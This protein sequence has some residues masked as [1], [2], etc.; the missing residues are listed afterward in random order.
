VLIQ[1]DIPDSGVNN[2]T[3]RYLGEIQAWHV[4]KVWGEA[5]K[6]ILKTYDFLENVLH[7]KGPNLVPFRYFYMSLAAFFFK[8]EDPDYELLQKYFWFYSF[9][10]DDLLTNTTDLRQHANLLQNAR[11]GQPLQF[12]PFVVD[13]NKLRAASYS[14]KG[15]LSRAILSLYASRNPRDWASPHRPVL[16]DVY[17]ILT[18]KPNLH[19]IFPLDFVEKHPGTN[20]LDSNSLMN[21]AYLTQITNLEISNKNPTVYLKDYLT[22]DFEGVLKEHLVPSDIVTWDKEDEL[23][24][25]A[26]D[27]F[28]EERISLVLECLRTKLKGMEFK[29]IDTKGSGKADG[30]TVSK[31]L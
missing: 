16:A 7:V 4:E 17:Y 3:D 1:R 6:A 28:I 23:P 9:H 29:T 14:S 31:P 27:T 8:N 24:E 10:N 22:E 18:D 2:I 25:N 12:A 20:E 19:H 5:K 21:I 13:R 11:R 26:L 15:R 30:D